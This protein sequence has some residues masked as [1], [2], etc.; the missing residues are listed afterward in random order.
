MIK[1]EVGK[2][3]Y[4]TGYMSTMLG[5]C[6]ERDTFGKTDFVVFRFPEEGLFYVGFKVVV[7]MTKDE[8]IAAIEA[9]K[10]VTHTL[11]DEDS[12]TDLKPRVYISEIDYKL[13]IDYGGDFI[14]EFSYDNMT[15][16]VGWELV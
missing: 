9:G 1:F 15:S 10:K 2:R 12:V 7:E 5:E 11:W 13:V 16:P 8:A 14:E 6:I 3:Y 4:F